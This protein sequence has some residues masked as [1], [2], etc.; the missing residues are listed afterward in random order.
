MGIF[1]GPVCCKEVA[2]SLHILLPTPPVNYWTPGYEW[3]HLSSL[4][5]SLWVLVAFIAVSYLVHYHAYTGAI[6]NRW[7]RTIFIKLSNHEHVQPYKSTRET[8]GTFTITTQY[9]LHN[10]SYHVCNLLYTCGQTWVHHI[11]ILHCAQ[12]LAHAHVIIFNPPDSHQCVAW[13]RLDWEWLW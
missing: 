7:V 5:H 3:I 13:S 9:T 6:Q 2:Q 8:S 1:F 10:A 11:L 12:L 4:A